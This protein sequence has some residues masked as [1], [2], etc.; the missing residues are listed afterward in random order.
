M[1]V[2]AEDAL[3][4]T[5][6]QPDDPRVYGL[7]KVLRV[8]HL[9]VLPQLLNVIRGDMSFI[10]PRP[11]RPEIAD[12]L[13]REVV[14][15]DERLLVRPGVTGL[16]QVTLRADR[17]VACVRRKVTVDLEYMRNAGPVFDLEIIGYTLLCVIGVK[18]RPDAFILD[19]PPATR[20]GSDLR[21]AR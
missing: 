20:D 3:G 4:P 13:R 18:R 15:Y 7:G 8:T 19:G 14:S 1:A 17:S 9:D 5:W 2:D 16:A 11:E 12:R 21:P 6:S 10:G